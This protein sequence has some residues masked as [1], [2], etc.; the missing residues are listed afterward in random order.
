MKKSIT[1][2]ANPKLPSYKNASL[3]AAVRVKD[4]LARMPLEE[5]AAQMVGIWQEKATKLLDAEGDF[6]F[7]KAKASPTY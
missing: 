3:P 1:A 5:K 4:L 7:A 2:R 6:D